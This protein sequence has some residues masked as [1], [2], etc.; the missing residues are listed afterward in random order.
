MVMRFILVVICCVCLFSCGGDD[1]GEVTEIVCPDIALAGFDVR[2]INATTETPLSNVMITAREGNIFE[3]VLMETS[4]GTGVYQG[5]F[6]REGSYILIIEL[7]GFQTV[8]TE[9]ITV[10]R[11]DDECNTLDTQALSFS[12]MEL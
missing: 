7:D 2:V 12:L 5:V 9:S 8:I 1:N 4:N 10:E 6:E 11:L 3:E